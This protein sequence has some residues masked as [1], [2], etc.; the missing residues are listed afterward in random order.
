MTMGPDLR[1]ATLNDARSRRSVEK[2]AA[3]E[4]GGWLVSFVYDATTDRSDFVIT[5]AEDI[6]AAPLATIELPV[7]VPYGFHGNWIAAG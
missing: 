4:D 5:D 3:V 2:R 6:T 1:I 7:R